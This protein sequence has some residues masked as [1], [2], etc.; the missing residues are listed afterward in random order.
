[1]WWHFG[2]GLRLAESSAILTGRKSS[3]EQTRVF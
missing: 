2:E 1:M 3:H